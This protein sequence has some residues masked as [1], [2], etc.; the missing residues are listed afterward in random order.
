MNYCESCKCLCQSGICPECGNDQLRQAE[1]DDWCFFLECNSTFGKML[2]EIFEN[3]SIPCSMIPCGNGTRSAL[4]L[5]LEN[6][7]LFVPYQFYDRAVDLHDYF[8]SDPT[9]DFKKTLIENFIAG[10][11]DVSDVMLEW[12]SFVAEEKE[13]ELTAIITEENLKPDETR[14]F[15]ENAFREGTVRTTGTDIDKL[16]PPMTRFGGGNRAEK[17]KSIIDKFIK[18]FERFL[19]VSCIFS[20]LI[21]G[22]SFIN[23]SYKIVG[24]THWSTESR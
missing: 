8:K 10:V 22:L 7:Q 11:N 16:M 9:E 15:I 14:K 4:G 3:E 1:N 2:N 18:F 13:K 17:K 19:T 5:N 12:R 24:S 21:F 23:E 20:L 6:L